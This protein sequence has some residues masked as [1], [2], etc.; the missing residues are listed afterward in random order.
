TSSF[1][2]RLVIS[3]SAPNNPFGRDIAVTVP[4]AATDG[5]FV[6]S[7]YDRR[8]VAGF[9][10]QL[11]RAWKAEADFT[12]DRTRSHFSQPA[13][14]TGAVFGAVGGGALDVLRDTNAFPLNIS[15]YAGLPLTSDEK[16]TLEDTVA[17]L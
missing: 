11:P 1:P 15:S 14:L 8:A 2:S 16:S 6:R 3:A 10:W 7:V 17:R 9:I 5:V 12:W 13:G 4:S